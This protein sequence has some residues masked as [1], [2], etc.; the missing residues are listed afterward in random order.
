MSVVRE[1]LA[2]VYSVSMLQRIYTSLKMMIIPFEQFAQFLPNDGV[3]LE[4][5]CG[6]GYVLN[7]LSLENPTRQVV[8][9]DP[10]LDRVDVAQGTIGDRQN[11]RF[12]A[13]DCRHMPEED[14]D[15][16]VI[17]DVLHHV[18]YEEQAKILEDVYRKLKPGG[19]L[20]M[21]ETD[22]KFRL[23]YFIFIYWLEMILYYGVEKLNFRKSAEWQR[24]LEPIGFSVQ[25]IIPNSRF[26][27]Y[28]TALFV[29]TKRS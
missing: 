11:I 17:A 29:C 22:I 14:F 25:H 27:P 4:V 16:I 24:I 7:Y 1:R 23:R 13:G 10:A 6:Y 28:I 2:D 8:G 3:V 15:G 26:F 21:R 5:G 9:N 18:P 20:V 12:V 19:V